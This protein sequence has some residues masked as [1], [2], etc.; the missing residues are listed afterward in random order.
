MPMTKRIYNSDYKGVFFGK[1]NNEHEY[2]PFRFA[3]P[4]KTGDNVTAA[5]ATANNNDQPKKMG[6]VDSKIELTIERCF[7]KPVK[8]VYHNNNIKKNYKP[9]GLSVKQVGEKFLESAYVSAALGNP[10]SLP[11]RTKREVIRE[12]IREHCE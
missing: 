1:R 6:V 5:A 2:R 7:C 9:N 10:M 4:E 8:A 3:A 11:T 12:P